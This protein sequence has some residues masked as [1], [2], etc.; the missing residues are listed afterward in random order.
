LDF[1]QGLPTGST[2]IPLPFFQPTLAPGAILYYLTF[3]FIDRCCAR[4][5]VPPVWADSLSSS[6]K[7]P[8]SHDADSEMSPS[9]DQLVPEFPISLPTLGFVVE[10]S[11]SRLCISSGVLLLRKDRSPSR[12]GRIPISPSLFRPVPYG[13]PTD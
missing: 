12:F 5:S 13:I 3:G 6:E 1:F 10:V 9:E 4:A 2:K 8:G 11:S 7:S